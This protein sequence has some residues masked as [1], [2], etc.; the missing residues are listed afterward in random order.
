MTATLLTDDSLLIE[1]SESGY[2]VITASGKVFEYKDRESCA[3]SLL[4]NGFLRSYE[5]IVNLC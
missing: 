1:D 4:F 5:Q 2:Q 3:N